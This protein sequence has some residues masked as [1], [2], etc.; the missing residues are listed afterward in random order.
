MNSDIN[1]Q[2]TALRDE[3]LAAIYSAWNKLPRSERVQLMVATDNFN[4]TRMHK[5]SNRARVEIAGKLGIWLI[6]NTE[7]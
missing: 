1:T 2:T 7:A 5:L 4:T 6:K 3:R